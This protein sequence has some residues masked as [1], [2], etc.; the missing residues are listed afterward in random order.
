MTTV[1][2]LWPSISPHGPEVPN[3]IWNLPYGVWV[4]GIA[5]ETDAYIDAKRKEAAGG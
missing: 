2:H 3:S 4:H 5:P 1:C